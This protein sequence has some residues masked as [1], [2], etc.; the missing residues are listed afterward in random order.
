MKMM[1]YSEKEIRDWMRKEYANDRTVEEMKG[2]EETMDFNLAVLSV[3]RKRGVNCTYAFEKV[4]TMCDDDYKKQC[5]KLTVKG[6]PQ[7][8]LDRLAETNPKFAEMFLQHHTRMRC[9][10]GLLNG[11]EEGY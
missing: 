2:V 8:I 5:Y 11:F 9:V 7:E 4:Y 10:V 3:G 1:S 6:T